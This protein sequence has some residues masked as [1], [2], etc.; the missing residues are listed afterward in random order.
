ML[1]VCVTAWAQAPHT[2]E[3][4]AGMNEHDGSPLTVSAE[5]LALFNNKVQYILINSCANCHAT[6]RGAAFV[7]TRATDGAGRRSTDANLD[8]VIRQISFEK[9]AASP[10]L[11]KAC[12]AHGGVA[13]SPIINQQAFPFV[14]LQSWVEMVVAQNRQLKTYGAAPVAV[15]ADLP[16]SQ[17][18]ADQAASIP[19]A[20]LPSTGNADLAPV[21]RQVDSVPSV[22]QTLA[23][24]TAAFP[25]GRSVERVNCTTPTAGT[26][27]SQPEPL[28]SSPYDPAPF[29][30]A[31][32]PGR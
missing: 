14:T 18:R 1:A 16:A 12:T 17:P 3:N 28:P 19:P 26:T 15:A 4:R 32:H 8:A 23:N 20:A 27:P 30:Q 31:A 10:L 5:C 2:G 11:V 22:T 25:S 7:L 24:E 9:P 6:G 21:A 13:H 29:N